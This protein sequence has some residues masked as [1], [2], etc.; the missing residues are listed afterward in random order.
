MV[1]TENGTEGR[2]ATI[3]GSGYYTRKAARYVWTGLAHEG[4]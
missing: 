3:A 4:S 1:W 2:D